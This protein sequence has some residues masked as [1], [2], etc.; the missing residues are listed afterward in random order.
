MAVARKTLGVRRVGHGGTLDPAATGLL[1]ILVGEGTKFTERL[2][3]ASKVYVALVSFGSETDTDDRE[4][5]VTRVAAAP[6]RVDAE[7]A[8]NAFRGVIRQTPP[9]YAAV[10]VGGRR[11]YARARAGETLTLAAREVQVH[12]LDVTRWS[13]DTDLGL[14]VVCSSGTYVRSLA[15]DL[16]RATGSAAH[17]GGLRRLAVGALEVS[18]ATPIDVLRREGQEAALSRLR[19]LGDET[20]VLPV[21]YL[22]V[23]A[24]KLAGEELHS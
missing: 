5:K 16:G 4:G 22:T 19:P 18:D 24:I 13:A 23:D 17:L 10:K 7:A 11:A 2:H 3:T 12:R 8:L 20:L 1:P 14:L 6:D 9:D 15:R 21:R